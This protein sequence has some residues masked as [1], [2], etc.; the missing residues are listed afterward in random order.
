LDADRDNFYLV[1]WLEGID[2]STTLDEC[3]FRLA[4]YQTPDQAPAPND[5]D[6]WDI[7]KLSVIG[8]DLTRETGETS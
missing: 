8:V 1:F 6:E 7:V 3:E 5:D 4:Y 2:L